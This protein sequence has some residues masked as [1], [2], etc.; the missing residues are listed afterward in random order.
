MPATKTTPEAI[1]RSSWQLFHRQGYHDT[2][3]QQIA[4]AAGL[5]KAGV[6]HHFGSKAGVMEGV[7]EYAINWYQRK[8]HS[9]IAGHASLEERLERFLRQ[10]FELCALNDGGGCFFANTILETGVGGQFSDLL[11]RFHT[12]WTEAVEQLFQERYPPEEARE[13]AYRLFADYQGSVVLY[14]LYRDPA[15]LEKLLARALATL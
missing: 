12:G 5:G 15:H 4:D 11:R 10:H 14:K 2:S 1:L 6:L 7:I 8:I 3:L 13:R 9:I